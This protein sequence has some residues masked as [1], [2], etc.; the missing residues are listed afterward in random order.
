MGTGMSGRSVAA[1][2]SISILSILRRPGPD[3]SRRRSAIIRRQLP[4]GCLNSSVNVTGGNTSRE[5]I[6]GGDPFLLEKKATHFSGP[7]EVRRSEN[8]RLRWTSVSRPFR[9]PTITT[10]CLHVRGLQ[11][12]LDIQHDDASERGVGVREVPCYRQHDLLL[13]RNLRPDSCQGRPPGESALRGVFPGEP[14]NDR[15]RPPGGLH[16]RDG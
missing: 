16:A 2:F 15:V 13:L 5:R 3:A 12:N 1:P 9:F 11:R 7:W 14:R 4:A 10:T 8:S 6:S